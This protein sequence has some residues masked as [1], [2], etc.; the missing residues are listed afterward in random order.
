M[1]TYSGFDTHSLI[2]F[3]ATLS[4]RLSQKRDKSRG[5]REGV[6]KRLATVMDEL[7]NRPLPV[8][9]KKEPISVADAARKLAAHFRK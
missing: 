1:G 3:A 2:R 9:K 5:G 8:E 6:E 7:R 4:L